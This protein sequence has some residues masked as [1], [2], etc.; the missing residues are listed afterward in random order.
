MK[1]PGF[2]RILALAPIL[3][4]CERVILSGN[5]TDISGKQIETPVTIEVNGTEGKFEG[6]KFSAKVPPSDRYVLNIWAEG[7]ALGSKVYTELPK[8]PTVL[9]TKATTNDF[10]PSQPI[11]L[12]DN[13]NTCYNSVKPLKWNPDPVKNKPAVY[14]SK[15][16]LIG[17]E[18]PSSIQPAFDYYFGTP[19]CNTGT[20]IQIDANSLVDSNGNPPPAQVTVSLATIDLWSPDGM[21]GDYSIA[22]QQPSFMQSFGAA[23]IDVYTKGEKG[24]KYNLKD[25]AK[26]TLIIPVDPGVLKLSK[27]IPKSV[28]FFVYNRK[29]GQWERDGEA[30]FDPEKRAYVTKVSHFSEFNMD[31]EKTNPACAKFFLDRDIPANVTSGD[32]RYYNVRVILSDGVVPPMG[33]IQVHENNVTEVSGNCYKQVVDTSFPAGYKRAMHAIQRIP[34]GRPLGLAVLNAS[35]TVMSISIIEVEDKGTCD[36]CGMVPANLWRPKCDV[37]AGCPTVSG[38]DPIDN[39]LAYPVCSGP[40]KLLN[41]GAGLTMAEPICQNCGDT[42]ATNNSIKLSW[43][44]AFP[45]G[46]TG[47]TFYLSGGRENGASTFNATDDAREVNIVRGSTNDFTFTL[48]YAISGTPATP[49]L[50][51]DGA[52]SGKMT[53]TSGA[54][55]AFEF[56]CAQALEEWHFKVVAK[57]NDGTDDQKVVS[58]PVIVTN[59][60]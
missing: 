44:Y 19:E 39:T 16:K 38:C 23:A 7:Y 10:D 13:Q 36:D 22:G 37:G 18:M 9:L 14:N 28:P 33:N 24:R 58:V 29:T 55:G 41:I 11:V 57:Y 43:A 5:V 56:T 6:G 27:D 31:V 49:D 45:E 21:P 32:D 42:N 60:P 30:N 59:N 54:F 52:V 4:S 2:I 8:D 25:G 51:C 40:A 53:V 26:A 20:T 46:S 50:V 35:N 12:V 48:D 3:I 34:P 47:R 15:G 1:L 17:F